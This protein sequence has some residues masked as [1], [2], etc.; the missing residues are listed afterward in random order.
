M[1]ENQKQDEPSIFDIE[2]IYFNKENF[3]DSS[4]VDFDQENEVLSFDHL[5]KEWN[6]NASR[7]CVTTKHIENPIL[8]NICSS[9]KSGN[10]RDVEKKIETK[11]VD[12]VNSC[13]D[14]V[15]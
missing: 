5:P 15:R 7:K 6:L 12:N 4:R 8:E 13:E 1:K 3:D 14:N 11:Q 2:V 9:P 10:D